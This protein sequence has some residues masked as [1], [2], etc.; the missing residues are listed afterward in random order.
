MA[1]R[2]KRPP[3][4]ATH[5]LAPICR[6]CPACGGSLWVAYHRGRTVTTLE[7]VSRLALTVVHCHNPAC[8]RFERPYRPEEEG[9]GALPHHEFGLDVI[10][11]IGTLRY[12]E[13]RS[14]PEIHQALRERQVTIAER[15]VT[16]LLERYE[17]LLALCLA[18]QTR[19]KDCLTQQGHVILAIDG[20]QPHK[21]QDVLWVLRDCLSGDVLLARSLDSGR[22]ADL[23]DMLREV[24]T[25]LPVPIHAVISDGQRTIR[26]AVQKVLPGIPHQLCQYHYLKEASKPILAA[27]RH[28]KTE[29]KKY[30]RGVREV[31]RKVAKREDPEADVVRSYC[32]A[33]RSSLSDE[34]K[35]PLQLPGVLMHDRLTAIVASLERVQQKGGLQPSWSSFRTWWDEGC[36][37]RPPCGH[38]CRPPKTGSCRRHVC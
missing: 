18:D 14:V 32:L 30:V 15:T 38:R 3:V 7:S 20:L 16:Y 36:L 2:T 4:T 24:T 1:R 8:S 31:E 12:R 28:A 21:H 11:L 17:E 5:T 34:G 10:A 35:P 26:L 27:D 6:T 13:H 23:S 22:E 29:F 25:W 33:V 9:A 19:L 37:P